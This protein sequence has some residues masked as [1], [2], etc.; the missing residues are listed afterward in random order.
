MASGLVGEAWSSCI[1][2]PSLISIARRLDGR[3]ER[4]C[5]ADGVLGSGDGGVDEHCIG[6]HFDG[7]GGMA[8]SADAGIHHDRNG[9]LVD[10][11]FDLGA[12]FDAAVAADGSAEWHHGRRAGILQSAGE[13]RVSVDVGEDSE[14]I[15]HEDFSGCEGL[16]G[17]RE[18]IVRVGVDFEFDPHGK[19]RRG[20]ESGE[21]NGFLRVHGSAG[22][23]QEEVFFRIDEL[24]DV[25]V[26]ILHAAE[27]RAAEGDG[28]DLASARR[29]G[30][31]H[32]FIGR[33][34]SCSEQEARGKGA[35]G[36]DEWLGH[37]GR[38][39]L[40]SGGDECFC[41]SEGVGDF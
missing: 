28:D 41:G 19:A 35:A 15:L 27:V 7:F 17:V 9:G 22:V 13:D 16:D 12:G 39:G 34:L 31:A 25:R 32:G 11:D 14:A 40:V 21:A 29:E 8:W 1:G 3:L 38:I 26:G 23:R 2:R 10:D 24:E 30:V 36:D 5:H 37:G 6:S 18:E 4:S 20:G 33:K